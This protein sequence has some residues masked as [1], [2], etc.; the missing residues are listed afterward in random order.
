MLYKYKLRKNTYF[1]VELLQVLLNV[2]NVC[3]YLLDVLKGAT[4]ID[5]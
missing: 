4:L 3:Q 2:L 5:R 1:V